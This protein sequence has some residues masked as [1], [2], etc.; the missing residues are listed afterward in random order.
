VDLSSDRLLITDVYKEREKMKRREELFMHEL[1][2]QENLQVIFVCVLIT[3]Q[4]SELTCEDFVSVNS[5]LKNTVF[6][7]C[8]QSEATNTVQRRLCVCVVDVLDVHNL[9]FS[10]LYLPTEQ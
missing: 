9:N 1:H 7:F 4:K 5:Y 6:T 10:L 8:G 3:F 2:I